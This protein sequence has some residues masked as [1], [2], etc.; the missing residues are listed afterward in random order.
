MEFLRRSAT[1]ALQKD[2]MSRF[3]YLDSGDSDSELLVRVELAIK[4]V[5][6]FGNI[7]QTGVLDNATI[8]LM[9][10]PRCGLPDILPSKPNRTKRYILGP[11]QGWTKRQLTYFIANWSPQIGKEAVRTELQRALAAW[12]RYSRLS[13]R[14]VFSPEADIIVAFGSGYHGDSVEH[15]SALGVR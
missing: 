6:K 9:K 15:V 11:T 13:F 5:Q 4:D 10:S 8:Q 7:K 3:G 14:E 12:S 1:I 2:F